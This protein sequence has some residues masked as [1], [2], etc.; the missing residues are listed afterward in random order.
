ML[1]YE[2]YSIYHQFFRI[3]ISDIWS[4]GKLH[5]KLPCIVRDL[6]NIKFAV[7][8]HVHWYLLQ[9]VDIKFGIPIPDDHVYSL[10][11]NKHI[12]IHQGDMMDSSQM[13]PEIATEITPEITPETIT[14]IIA[15]IL[16]ICTIAYGIHITR[17][18]RSQMYNRGKY[19]RGKP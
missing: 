5:W 9:E 2:R 11:W 17:R 8:Y 19:N 13:A 1:N 14:F 12:W 6:D 15:L 3:G 18:S 4:S 10:S 16:L 7:T